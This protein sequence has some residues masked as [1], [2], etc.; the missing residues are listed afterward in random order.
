MLRHVVQIHWIEPLSDDQSAE[1]R[2]VLDRVSEQVD[3]LRGYSHGPDAGVR[4]GCC[5]YVIVADFDDAEGFAAY[6]THPASEAVRAVLVPIRKGFS[7][8]QYRLDDAATTTV[9][10]KE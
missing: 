10:T 4:E 8:G 2:T 6:N 5:D 1:L 7:V 3:S 9:G